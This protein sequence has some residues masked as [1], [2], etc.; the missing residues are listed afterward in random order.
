MVH[1]E[2]SRLD[3]SK[4][5]EA[6]RY[7]FMMGMVI[8]RPVALVKSLSRDGVLIA[9]PFSQFVVISVTPPPPG[10]VAHDGECGLKDTVRNIL[11]SDEYVINT[12]AEPMAEQ[13]QICAGNF[14]P[15]VSEVDEVG[16]QP[17]PSTFVRPARIAEP[18]VH[19]ECRPHKTVDFGNR[20]SGTHLVVG[21][22]IAAHCAD[23]VVSG[24][25]VSH[26]AINALTRIA[27]RGFCRTGDNFDG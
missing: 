20:G 13:V 12:V 21:E 15:S 4:F 9:A 23:G 6:S 5:E 24:H 2:Y 19:F 22:V 8:P 3:I 11:E 16:C 26:Q 10:F 7:K 17:L 14:P 1:S 25:R 18:L 27:G